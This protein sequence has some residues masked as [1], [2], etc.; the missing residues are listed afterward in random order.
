MV[1]DKIRLKY[2][3]LVKIEKLPKGQIIF[4]Y[5]CMSCHTVDGYRSMKK[6]IGT[7]DKDS[8]VGFLNLLRQTEAGKNPYHGIMPPFAGDDEDIKLLANYLYSINNPTNTS[9]A[10]ISS[11]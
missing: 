2:V 1:P 4:R 10:K 6:L 11:R 5:E 8:I 7:R 3:A 9:N